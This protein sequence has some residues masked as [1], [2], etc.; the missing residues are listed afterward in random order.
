MV[1]TGGALFI[2]F[3]F[4]EKDDAVRI[5]N[6]EDSFYCIRYG[7]PAVVVV[8]VEAAG[9]KGEV[10]KVGGVDADGVQLCLRIDAVGGFA[11]TRTSWNKS[12]EFVA[13]DFD[14]TSVAD[15][16]DV[17]AVCQ[18]PQVWRRGRY[19]QPRLRQYREARVRPVR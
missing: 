5:E 18:K 13:A 3:G 8:D 12:G 17:P 7:A 6:V 2:L 19:G 11:V 1:D 15:G 9:N 16:A 14:G 10:V 4:Y